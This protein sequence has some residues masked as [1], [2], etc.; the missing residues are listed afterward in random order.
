[1]VCWRLTV[2]DDPTHPRGSDAYEE[3]RFEDSSPRATAHHNRLRRAE[4]RGIANDYQFHMA[5]DEASLAE[6]FSILVDLHQRRRAHH[7]QI[8]MFARLRFCRSTAMRPKRCF[9]SGQLWLAWMTRQGVPVSVFYCSADG[10]ILHGYQSGLNPDYLDDEPGR[11]T[12]AAVLRKALREGYLAPR[13]LA[14]RRAVQKPPWRR[15]KVHADGADWQPNA[16]Q[17]KPLSGWRSCDEKPANW[18]DR[19]CASFAPLDRRDP[20]TFN[21]HDRGRLRDH[22]ADRRASYFA[23]RYAQ[24][25]FSDAPPA[26]GLADVLAL[27]VPLALWQRQLTLRFSTVLA[28]QWSLFS[29][30]D[31]AAR[32]GW[33]RRT[34]ALLIGDY[35]KDLSFDAAWR[36][37]DQPRRQRVI[38]ATFVL[39]MLFAAIVSIPQ[40]FGP[41]QCHYFRFASQLN[42]EQTSDRRP[43]QSTAECHTVPQHEQHLRDFGW[44]CERTGPLGLATV[45]DRI[46]YT[47]NLLDPNALA[48]ALVMAAA[49]LVGLATLARPVA[50]TLVRLIGLPVGL[51]VIL[52][53]SRAAQV[54]MGAVLLCFFYFASAYREPSL[55]AVLSSPLLLISTRNEAEAAYST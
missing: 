55:A 44:A 20:S 36:A 45:V 34:F 39:A 51:A 1:M 18:P 29:G 19:S 31:F 8:G 15:T 9:A 40:R 25:R 21:F 26:S 7:G 49:L 54:A 28:V 6:G 10:P 53:A 38:Y 50:E 11:D 52:A 3:C 48:L 2:A 14:R 5:S 12:A 42:H 47:G 37:D 17:G 43:C 22:C 35:A 24:R 16:R 30:A 4:R 46:H 23:L 27:A 13:S 33:G 32:I 41:K